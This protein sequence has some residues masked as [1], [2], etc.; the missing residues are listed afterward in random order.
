M[1]PGFAGKVED[2][3][4]YGRSPLLACQMAEDPA[5]I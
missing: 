5:K 1:L 3:Y 4:Y 2:A